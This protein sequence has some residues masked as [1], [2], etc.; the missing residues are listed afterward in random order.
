[1]TSDLD[2]SGPCVAGMVGHKMPHYCMQYV[3]SDVWLWPF[4]WVCGWDVYLMF[5]L[6]LLGPC[7]AW[8]VRQKMPRYCLYYL[9]SY[10]W[11][12]PFRPLCGWCG[13]T[14]DASLLSLLFDHWPLTLT[15]QT[16]LWLAWLDRRCLA[17]VCILFVWPLTLTFQV[18]VWLGFCLFCLIPDL[19][20]LTFTFKVPVWQAWLDTRC[21][22]TVCLEIL[23]I[24]LP[25][26]SLMDCVSTK[27]WTINHLGCPVKKPERPLSSTNLF[28]KKIRHSLTR[29]K[30]TSNF[31]SGPLQIIDGAHLSGHGW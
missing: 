13:Q 8:V 29:K 25:G 26:W 24:L 16:S 21:R 1:M 20:H 22:G 4:R 30:F 14:P 12:L 17:T 5:D 27:G 9:T 31:S 15:F 28:R 19:W 11:L 7:V 18:P 6:G 23:W 2:H 3:T 10:L